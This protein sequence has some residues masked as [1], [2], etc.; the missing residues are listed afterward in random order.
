[1]SLLFFSAEKEIL[2]TKTWKK[3]KLEIEVKIK[4]P[5]YLGKKDY[6][7]T[8]RLNVCELVG[9][10]YYFLTD[11][12]SQ[13]CKTFQKYHGNVSLF[14]WWKKNKTKS[15]SVFKIISRN[16]LY[17]I[18]TEGP[19]IIFYLL[20]LCGGHIFSFG[21]YIFISYNLSLSHWDI[22]IYKGNFIF[23]HL[24]LKITM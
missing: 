23:N 21:E 17:E 9:F 13:K 12:P 5:I 19:N 11:I 16:G 2:L 10:G 14:Q 20:L 1:M 7:K 4:S 15:L 24:V 18:S 3:Y 8:N 22:D 6:N